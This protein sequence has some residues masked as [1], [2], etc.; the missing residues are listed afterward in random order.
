MRVY[1]EDNDVDVFCVALRITWLPSKILSHLLLSA[2]LPLG[3]HCV[4]I[5]IKQEKQCVVLSRY[6]HQAIYFAD[7]I[8]SIIVVNVK[9][10]SPLVI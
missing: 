5:T 6:T 1:T 7:L 8:M 4:S 9:Q 3:G 10:V 2:F